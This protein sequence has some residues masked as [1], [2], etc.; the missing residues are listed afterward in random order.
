MLAELFDAE[1]PSCAELTNGTRKL[2]K[3]AMNPG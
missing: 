3:G 1:T 2:R